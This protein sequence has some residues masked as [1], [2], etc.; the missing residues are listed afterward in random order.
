MRIVG[1][2]EIAWLPFVISPS[3]SRTKIADKGGM[4]RKKTSIGCLFWI[5]LVLLVLVIF[6]FNRKTIDAVLKNTGFWEAISSEESPPRIE[7]TEE[8]T[9]VPGDAPEE[10]P[11]EAVPQSAPPEKP[12]LEAD[13]PEEE[14]ILSVTPPKPRRNPR[15]TPS[16]RRL[17]RSPRESSA[18][19]GSIS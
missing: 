6:L 2:L 3:K 14:T 12:P 8:E 16:P 9:E 18:G 10:I 15:K 4:K 13:P 11:E 19:P 1:L 17:W 7:R 5:A